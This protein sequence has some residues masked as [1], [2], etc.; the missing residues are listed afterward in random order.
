MDDSQ[1]LTAPSQEYDTLLRFLISQP[2]DGILPEDPGLDDSSTVPDARP[3]DYDSFDE[4]DNVIGE[5]T[6]V[7]PTPAPVEHDSFDDED[8]VLEDSF[9]RY[10]VTSLIAEQPRLRDRIGRTGRVGRTTVKDAK[11]NLQNGDYGEKERDNEEFV[12]SEE[13]SKDANNVLILFSFRVCR[14]GN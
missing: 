1:R 11:E 7:P 5:R 10:G 12:E 9:D 6:L 2:Q 4:N 13:K 14:S 3:V 8:N